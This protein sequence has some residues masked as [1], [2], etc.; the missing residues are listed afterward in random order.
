[1]KEAAALIHFCH[2]R[3]GVPCGEGERATAVLGQEAV[4]WPSAGGRRKAAEPRLGRK[5]AH[6]GRPDEPVHWFWAGKG[7][8]VWCAEMG[9]GAGE[10]WAGMGISMKNSNWAAK[11][12]GPN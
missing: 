9:Q 6:A 5:A 3:G 2:G 11:A 10:V 4:G 1:M 8:R 12:N 7:R